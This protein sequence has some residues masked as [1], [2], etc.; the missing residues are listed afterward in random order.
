MKNLKNLL[1]GILSA[2]IVIAVGAS[3]YNAYASPDAQTAAAPDTAI[4]TGNGNG[5]GGN[6]NAN[7]NQNGNGAGITGIPASDLSAEET[8]SLLFMREEEKLARDVYNALYAIWGQ[9]TF[10]NIAASEQ[11]HMDEVKLLLD[12]YGLTD[13]VLAPGQFTD[14][15]LQALYDQLTAQG[16]ISLADALKVGAAIE[17]IDILDLQTRLAQTDNADIQWVYNNLMNG[18]YHHL[19]AFTGALLQTTGEV[20]QPQY[21]SAEVYASIVAGSMGNGNQGGNGYGANGQGGQSAQSQ[22]GSGVPQA[23]VTNVT[24]VHGVISAYDGMGISLTT[25]DGQAVYVDTGNPR[26]SQS[27]GFTPQIGEGVTVVM[28]PGDQGLYSAISVTLDSMGITYTFRSET[29]QPLWSGG[30]GNGNHP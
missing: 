9:P 25:D 12:R 3:A 17:E 10:Q 8:A 20:Y 11:M 21:L 6:G 26:F 13:P 18:S 30:N 4:Q 16:S 24:T 7:G 2:V 27:I 1:I 22:A 14:P 5:K 23:N 15:N 19:N 28:F 29:G